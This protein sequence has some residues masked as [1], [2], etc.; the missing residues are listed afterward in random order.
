[1][2]RSLAIPHIE[3]R[4]ADLARSTDFYSQR[5]GFI[6]QRQQG[7]SVDL[8]TSPEAE[9]ILRLHGAPDARHAPADT[10]GLFHA[11]LLFPSRAALGAWLRRAA[12]QH[13]EFDGF[14]D[15]AVSEAIYFRDPDDNGLEFYAD[16]PREVWPMA[17]GQV[18]MVTRPLD[19]ESLLR[20]ASLSTPPLLGA[21]WGHLHF[22]VTNLD[23]SEAFYT[24]ALGLA[25]TQRNYP[26][27][28]FLAADGYHHH[29][30]LNIWGRPTKPQPTGMLGLAGATFMVRSA[31]RPTTIVDPD[32]I[33]LHVE[34]WHE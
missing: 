20:S 28:R 18:D 32:G 26:G 15:H 3:L 9:S 14:S 6:V 13:V 7:G 10:A 17:N 11:A 33:T 31:E 1:M 23:R 30:G 4:V 19:V 8:A 34:R 25:V 24:H 16:R 5:L 2:T 21:T 29:V 27:A 22:R 12:E